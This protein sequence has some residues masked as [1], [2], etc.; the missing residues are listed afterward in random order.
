MQAGDVY[1]F[2]LPSAA[3]VALLLWRERNPSAMS[4]RDRFAGLLRLTAP[5]LMGVL[6]IIAVF[7][8]PYIASGSIHMLVRGIAGSAAARMVGLGGRTHAPGIGSF[9]GLVSIAL[10]LAAMRARGTRSAWAV[11]IVA[12][13][14]TGVVLGCA[15]Q[16]GLQPPWFMAG[17]LTPPAV[18]LGVVL[19]SRRDWAA[20]SA[21]SQQRTMLL[22]ALAAVC[23][24][25]QF[26]FPYVTYFC[27]TAPLTLLAVLALV[28]LR[29]SPQAG[30][31]LA[32]LL[33]FFLSLGVFGLVPKHIY[34]PDLRI[35]AL[36]T[37]RLPRSGGLKVDATTPDYDDLVP[38]LQ[39]H[40]ANGLL[41]AGNDCPELYFLSGLKNPTNDDTGAP[42]SD[43]LAALRSGRLRLVAINDQSFFAGAA[44]PPELRAAVAA[45]LPQSTRIGR[46]S[47]YWR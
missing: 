38:F 3:C 14:L 9:W 22:V 39:M 47:I 42:A 8:V 11:T 20:A 21:V 26:P 2:L 6:A 15:F 36:H 10:I 27:Y 34:N 18:V 17:T 40:S 25:V 5:F 24:L 13:T 35:G 1:H 31:M 45:S 32:M 41:Y 23:S 46:F 28:S 29:R 12:A 7:L 43:L 19:L 44:T 30:P 4:S 37:L 16:R 33:L